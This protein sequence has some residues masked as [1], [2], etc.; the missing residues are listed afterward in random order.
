[1]E[2]ANHRSK[3]GKRLTKTVGRP[4]PV[5]GRHP[6]FVVSVTGMIRRRRQ[7]LTVVRSR[8]DAHAAGALSFP[9]GRIESDIDDLERS[10][11]QDVLE[12]TLRR[13]IWEEVRLE[14]ADISYLQSRA[15]VRDDGHP[16]V[17]VVFTCR[18]RS[19]RPRVDSTGEITDCQWLLPEEIVEHEACR[20][21]LREMVEVA[22]HCRA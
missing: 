4:A 16:V 14:V 17:N 1:M 21:W 2:N 9:G 20:Q 19:G 6:W 15:F 7:Y 3:E 22:R 12:S 8:D 10:S 11:S 18:H 5:Q 13:E